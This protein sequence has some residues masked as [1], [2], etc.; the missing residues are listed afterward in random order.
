MEEETL[1]VL[2]VAIGQYVYEDTPDGTRK[3]GKI[4]ESK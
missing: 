1:V 2:R 4:W 3:S